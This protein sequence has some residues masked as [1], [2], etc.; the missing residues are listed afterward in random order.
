MAAGEEQSREY[1]RRHRL[2]ELLQHLGALLLFHRPEKPREFLIQ[3]LERV[4]AGRRAEGEY[5][6]LMDEANVEAMFGLL[7]VL[8]QGHI[9]PVQYR[10]ALKTLG[11]ST[12]DLEV[13]DDENITLEV[14]KEGVKKRMLESWAVY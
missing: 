8:G 3:A 1:L 10:E 6:D 9:T 4:K 13:G 12:E 2:P 11:L 5:P 7:D 14:F